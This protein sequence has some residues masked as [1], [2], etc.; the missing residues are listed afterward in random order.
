MK[1]DNNNWM[2]ARAKQI[3]MECLKEATF[4]NIDLLLNDNDPNIAPDFVVRVKSSISERYLVVIIKANGQPRNARL[5]INELFRYTMN[6][7]DTYGIFMAP[8]ISPRTAQIC[9]ESEIGFIDFAGNC[10][11]SFDQIYIR[12]EGN[13]NATAEKRNLRS[14]YS[15]KAERILRVLL[16][17]PNRKWKMHELSEEADVSIGLVH[18]VISLMKDR[19]W[20]KETKSQGMSIS[21]FDALLNE[22]SRVYSVR[23]PK[24][25]D[26]FF[27][28]DVDLVEREIAS[29]CKSISVNYAFTGLSAASRYAPFVRYQRVDCYLDAA[30]NSITSIGLKRVPV[31]A[32]VRIILPY[33]K[34]VFY[35]NQALNG[36]NIVSPIQNYLD[37]KA[38]GGRAEEGAEFLREQIIEPVWSEII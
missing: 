34:G 10:R 12:I 2:E 28:G 24:S 15:P 19:E 38:E 33:D 11:I 18:N 25:E 35:G 29:L 8:Y 23:K 7:P 1:T 3:L 17:S 20:A 21:D 30:P 14:L 26:Y 22:W 6:H 37:L 16:F 27:L 9:A 36:I 4:L 31:G 13:K 5:A 32:N